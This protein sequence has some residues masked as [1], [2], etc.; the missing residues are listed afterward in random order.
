M[1]SFHNWHN[2][3]PLAYDPNGLIASLDP[4]YISATGQAHTNG[5]PAQDLPTASQHCIQLLPDDI[6]QAYKIA[7]EAIK[8]S[9]GQHQ[10]P[11]WDLIWVSVDR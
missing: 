8:H 7:Y 3:P 10:R 2:P 5:P 1:D 4:T 9:I 11:N 6:R